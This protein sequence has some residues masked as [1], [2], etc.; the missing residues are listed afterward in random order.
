MHVQQ[1]KLN[2][3]A[4]CCL[5]GIW[6]DTDVTQGDVVSIKAVWNEQ[7]RMYCIDNENGIIVVQPD[8]L[9]SGTTVVGSLFC[10]RK[11]VLTERFRGV[12]FEESLVVGNYYTY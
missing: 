5:K 1:K 4:K 12:D 10:A 6:L 7:R 3:F 11:T 8:Y 9:V 2:K